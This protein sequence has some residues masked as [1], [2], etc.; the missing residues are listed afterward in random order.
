MTTRLGESGRMLLRLANLAA[1]HNDA[2]EI[3]V[4]H[5]GG[6]LCDGRSGLSARL[7]AEYPGYSEL[8]TKLPVCPA[9]SDPGLNRHV[10]FVPQAKIVKQLT[11]LATQ[12]GAQM[13]CDEIGSTHYLLA[14]LQA[15]MTLRARPFL[16][17]G[18]TYASIRAKL[19]RFSARLDRMRSQLLLPGD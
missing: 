1:V 10:R 8:L 16:E 7:L 15:D 17:A 14:L 6:A 12:E 13:A 18:V 3:D 2:D 4:E 19:P 5:I 9:E 11:I